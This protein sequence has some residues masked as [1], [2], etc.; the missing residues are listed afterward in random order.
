MRGKTEP[1]AYDPKRRRGSLGGDEGVVLVG[2][3]SNEGEGTK[4]IHDQQNEELY[5]DVRMRTGGRGIGGVKGGGK[6]AS[7]LQT[8][9]RELNWKGK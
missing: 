6:A 9:R 7:A 1:K 8:G 5:R 4:N 3:G 2:G